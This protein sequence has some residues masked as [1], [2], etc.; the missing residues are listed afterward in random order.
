MD[1]Y[2]SQYQ[3]Q[4]DAEYRAESIRLLALAMAYKYPSVVDY[5]RVLSILVTLDDVTIDLMLDY[6]GIEAMA[7]VTF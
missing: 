6:Y 7:E 5:H 3:T 2:L 4:Q 1:H